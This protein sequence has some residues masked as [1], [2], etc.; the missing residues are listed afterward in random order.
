[1]RRLNNLMLLL[2]LGCI[3]TSGLW[4][5]NENS[6]AVNFRYGTEQF[7]AN[8]REFSSMLQLNANETY[9]GKFY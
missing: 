6:Y 9:N 7:D 5:Q 3:S 8:A 2:L 1:M 4:A